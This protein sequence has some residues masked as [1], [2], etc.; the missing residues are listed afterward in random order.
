MRNVLTPV[1][2]Y[3]FDYRRVRLSDTR[4]PPKA[5]RDGRCLPLR[6]ERHCRTAAVPKALS[7]QWPLPR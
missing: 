4:R 3:Q 2:G 1:S 7:W 6:H 5:H